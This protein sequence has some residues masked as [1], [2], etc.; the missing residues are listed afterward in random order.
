MRLVRAFVVGIG[1]LL[2]AGAIALAAAK[3]AATA[4][5][6]KPDLWSA[7]TFAGLEL[8]GIGPALTSGRIGDFAVNPTDRSHYFAAVSSGGV[9]KTSNAGTTWTPVFDE[10]GSYSIGCVVMD[11]KNPVVVWVGTGENNSQRSVGYGD[12][13]YRSLDGGKS[14]E[15][16]G[17]KASEHIGKIVID[18]RDSNI[19][20]VAAQGPLWGPGGDRGLF[21]TI[22]GGKTWKAVLTISENTGVSDVVIDPRDPDLLIASAYQR[23]RHVFTMIDGGPESAI[24]K[25]SDGGAS[26]RKVKTGLPTV[27]LGRI[28]LALSPVDPDI[29]FATVEA[30]EG[31]GGFFRSSDRAETWEKRGD[32]VSGGPQYYQ[33]IFCDPK[34]VDRVYA[35]DVFLMVTEDGGKTFKKLGEKHKHVDNHALWIDPANTDYLLAGCDGG[36]YESFDRGAT[37]NFKANLPVAQFYRVAVDNALPF[38]NIYGGTQDN[39]TLGGPSRTTN[40]H[41]IANADWSVVTGG[42]GFWSGIDPEDPNIVYGESQYGF[43]VRLDRRS[44]ERT[45]IKPQEGKGEPPLRWNWDSP[46]VISPHSRTRL[47]FAANRLFRSDDRGDTWRPISGDLTR[48]VDRNTLPVMGKVWGPD[49][50]AKNVSTS[51]FGNIVSLAE[52]KLVEGLIFAGTDDGLVQIT[53][54]GGTNWRKIA[55]F[56]GV[57][58]MAYVSDLVASQHDASTL[59]AAFD[60]HKNSDFKPYLLRSHDRGRTWVSIAGDLPPRGSV[61]T[62]AEDPANPN[63][64]FAGT[65]LGLFFSTDS[66]GKWVQLKGGMPVIAIKD[67]AIQERERALVVA[68]FGRGFFVLDDLT[69]LRGLTRAKLEQEA[70]VFAA[71]DALEYI[72]SRPLELRGKSFQ[73]EAFYTAP[74]PPFGAV[75]SFYLKDGL[76]SKKELRQEAEKEAAKKSLALPYPSHDELRA[77]AD[78]EEPAVVIT[79]SDAAANVVRRFEAPREKGFHRVAWDLRYPPAVPAEAKKKDGEENI[80]AEPDRGPL[81]RPGAYRAVVAK[82]VGGIVTPFA[83]P[84]D[85]NVV[86]LAAATLPTADREQLLAFQQQAARLQRAAL[87]AL[88]AAEDVKARLPLIKQALLDTPAAPLR[89]REQADGIEKRLAAL[90]IALRGDE[91]LRKRNENTPISIT[92]RVQTIIDDGWLSHSAPTRTQEDAHALASEQLAE[93][94]AALRSLLETDLKTLE[95]AMEAAGAPWT[96]GRLPTWPND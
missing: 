94:L 72:P 6:K 22:D 38:F 4:E 17:L 39:F 87:G 66:G 81:A 11:P 42:D 89:L 77:E 41:G 78:E 7:E 57:P 15:N 21:K 68:T 70:L 12:G 90:L 18:P 25:S 85:F 13:V 62:I 23:R 27:E 82:R 55:A 8:R 32:W 24:Y 73:G 92:E 51:Y 43:L 19:V 26:W 30:A 67:L 83:E 33:E 48:Q 47:Y 9:W 34:D 44:G 2:A 3:P 35:M 56:P 49:A 54:D 65:E 16:M 53:E 45:G 52:S 58:E 36:I 40:I 93:T 1:A 86:P 14:W 74:N 84:I 69:P 80:F 60:N 5:E 95:T 29:V 79:V 20:Y 76:K 46:L 63:L 64:L 10:Q 88:K 91:A 50:V 71:R 37:W 31:K 28:G 96:P 59:L 61:N 75:F